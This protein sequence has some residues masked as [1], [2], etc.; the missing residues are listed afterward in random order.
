VIFDLEE[1]PEDL[2]PLAKAIDAD[3]R[4]N[5]RYKIADLIRG[6]DPDTYRQQR[7]F[8]ARITNLEESTDAR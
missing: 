6:A 4:A 3:A 1:L 5:P 7:L 8:D 2:R